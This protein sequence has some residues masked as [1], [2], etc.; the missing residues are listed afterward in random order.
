MLLVIVAEGGSV[1][2]QSATRTTEG[3]VDRCLQTDEAM[4]VIG[5]GA[6]ESS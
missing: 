1:S 2:R 3:E 4:L 5:D 6:S